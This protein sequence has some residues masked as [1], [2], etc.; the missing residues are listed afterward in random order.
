MNSKF[1]V[2]TIV[3]WL[4]VIMIACFVIAA[5]IFIVTGGINSFTG[6]NQQT[7]NDEKTL[8]AEGIKEINLRTISTDINFITTDTN[9]IKLHLHGWTTSSSKASIPELATNVENNNLTA[10]VKNKNGFINIGFYNTSLTLD[11]YVPKTYS[12]SIHVNTTSGKLTIEQLSLASFSFNSVSGDMNLNSVNTND[13]V[14]GTTSGNIKLDAFTG[15][16]KFNSVSGGLS[17]N[18]TAFNNNIS[19]S[20]VSGSSTLT[21]P[22]N[23]EFH[24]NF[25]STSGNLNNAFPIV[26]NGTSRRHDVEGTVG[27][28][29]NN[30]TIETTSGNSSINKK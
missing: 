1:N 30:V 21:L 15:N 17:A 25:N 24:L 8:S 2:K 5:A 27:S 18:Y 10:E 11:V 13:T 14:I 16:L 19:V 28:D 4:T 29:T 22:A 23:S 3:L 20:S 26:S 7:I 6:S 12:K 9:D